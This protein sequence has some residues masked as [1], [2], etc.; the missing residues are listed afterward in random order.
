MIKFGGGLA[1]D[2]N[3]NSVD[4]LGDDANVVSS[5]GSFSSVAV[6]TTAVYNDFTYSPFMTVSPLWTVSGFSFSL[7]QIISESEFTVPSGQQFLSLAGNGVFTGNGF[8]AT[9]GNWTFSANGQNSQF[10]FSSVSVP[11]PGTALLLGVGLIG[12]GAVC[13]LRK[14]V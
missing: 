1:L 13:K 10:A 2:F 4:I 12:F 14:A 7:K 3:T 6:G 8:D 9:Y 5:N 11:E